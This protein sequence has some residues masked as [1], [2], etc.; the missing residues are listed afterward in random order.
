MSKIALEMLTRVTC[1]ECTAPSFRCV[2][3]RPGVFDTG[4][5]AYLRSLDPAEFPSASM[6]RSFKENG[7]LKDP[8]EVAARIVDRLVMGPIDNGRTYLHTDL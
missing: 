5:Q 3:L 2:T 8:A 7:L 6:F 1:A 4:M